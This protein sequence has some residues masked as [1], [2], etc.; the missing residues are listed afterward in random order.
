MNNVAM[1]DPMLIE[2]LADMYFAMTELEDSIPTVPGLALAIGFNRS[3]DINVTLKNYEEGL[4]KYP[5]A[6]VGT[7]LRS[8]TKIE[9]KYIVNGLQ[10]KFP[11]ALVKFCLGAYHDRREKEPEANGAGANTNIMVVFER[12]KELDNVQARRL[13]NNLNQPVIELHSAN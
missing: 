8:L 4:S 2:T 10:D 9:D 3:Y 6:S 11:S 7:I 1:H 12:P 13:T 5:E